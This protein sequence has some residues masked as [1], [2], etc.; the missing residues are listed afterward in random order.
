VRSWRRHPLR[1]CVL[2]VDRP[3]GTKYSRSTTSR[4]CRHLLTTVPYQQIREV[5]GIR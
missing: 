3:D 1:P 2:S 5:S 4:L